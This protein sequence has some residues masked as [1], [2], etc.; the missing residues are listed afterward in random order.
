MANVFILM[1][2]NILIQIYI[3]IVCF[4]GQD[5]GTALTQLFMTHFE[6]YSTG[7]IANILGQLA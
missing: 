6:P 1:A 7:E 4:S 5:K 2:H 3:Q